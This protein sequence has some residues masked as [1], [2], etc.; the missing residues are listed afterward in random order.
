MLDRWD[1][2]LLDGRC[3]FGQPGQPGQGHRYTWCP[4]PY[5]LLHC[6]DTSQCHTAYQSNQ[7]TDT[8]NDVS[9]HGFDRT[10]LIDDMA[11]DSRCLP[12]SGTAFEVII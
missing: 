7:R 3:W 8:Y 12:V 2:F 4:R 6:R 1:K 11:K 9:D 10:G 5:V